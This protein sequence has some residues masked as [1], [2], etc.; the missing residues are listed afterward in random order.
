MKVDGQAALAAFTAVL[1]SILILF[2]LQTS[3]F[4]VMPV[5][6]PPQ[7]VDRGDLSTVGQQMS[8]FLWRY[9]GLDVIAQA[10]LLLA[11]AIGSLAMLR[12]VQEER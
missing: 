11:S 4:P 5:V 12:R 8:S 10:I 9:R 7:T 1:A 6:Y 2:T 3:S